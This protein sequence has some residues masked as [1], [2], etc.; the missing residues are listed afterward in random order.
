MVRVI[1]EIKCTDDDGETYTVHIYQDFIIVRG[2]GGV[3]EE[4]PGMKFAV[5]AGTEDRVNTVDAEMNAFQIVKND[6][7]I[8]RITD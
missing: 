4:L 1:D 5:L 3:A 2:V 6:R 7:I 8:R